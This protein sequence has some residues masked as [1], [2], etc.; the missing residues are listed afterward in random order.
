MHAQVKVL[1]R[2]ARI[3]TSKARKKTVAAQVSKA[4]KTAKQLAARKAPKNRVDLGRHGA[5]G[6]E[7]L[8]FLPGSTSVK[9]GESVTFAMDAK[10][11]EVHTATTGPGDI[12][13]PSSYLGGIAAAFESPVFPPVG[14]YASEAPTAGTTTYTPAL[15]GNGYWNSGLLDDLSQTPFGKQSTVTFGQAG[16]YTFYC[17]IH[18]FM[19]GTVTVS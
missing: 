13:N 5:D 2:T 4:L 3:P 11:F 7:I 17:L 12:M 18:P 14:T 6:T 10:S 1:P 16:T 15:H 19:K 8:A 9:V